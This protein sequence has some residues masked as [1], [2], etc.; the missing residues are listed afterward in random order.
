MLCHSAVGACQIY[1]PVWVISFHYHD[2]YHS[3]KGDIVSFSLQL[4]NNCLSTSDPNLEN[5]IT[6][7]RTAVSQQFVIIRYGFIW[8]VQKRFPRIKYCKFSKC[9]PIFGLTFL[10]DKQS[11]KETSQAVRV[12]LWSQRRLK[13][14]QHNKGR[15]LTLVFRTWCCRLYIS[16]ALLC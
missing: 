5:I 10:R 7:I 6:H 16:A 8:D 3:T 2:G 15:I 4:H 9:S 13:M 11:E 14:H 12:V 1:V